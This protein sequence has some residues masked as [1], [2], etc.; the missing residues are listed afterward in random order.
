MPEVRGYA[1]QSPKS[2]L[3][4]HQ[5]ETQEHLASLEIHVHPHAPRN[6]EHGQTGAAAERGRRAPASMA[7]ANGSKL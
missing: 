5:A 3:D 4:D 6:R 7:G 2:P 1:V